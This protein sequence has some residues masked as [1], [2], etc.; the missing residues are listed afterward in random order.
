MEKI[1]VNNKDQVCPICGLT[2][3]AYQGF[4]D[5]A[6]KRHPE[7]LDIIICSQCATILVVHVMPEIV[8][9]RQI[10]DTELEFLQREVSHVY[11]QL[12]TRQQQV[13][14]MSNA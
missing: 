6:N 14:G 2:S 9:L 10:E 13:R 12:M 8:V 1:Y 5:E 7:H 11:K 3:N 4:N